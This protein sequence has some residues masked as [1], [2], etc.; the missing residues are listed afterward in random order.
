MKGELSN[1]KTCG[2][3]FLKKNRDVCNDCVQK[4]L[5][6]IES[7]KNF[8]DQSYLENV[9]LEQINLETQIEIKQIEDFLKRGKLLGYLDKI[10]INC[11]ICK[12]FIPYGQGTKKQFVCE[13]C[14]TDLKDTFEIKENKTK[15]LQCSKK[16][17]GKSNNSNCAKYGFKKSY[18]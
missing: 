9:S 3:V 18:D 15:L 8:I 13:K 16:N 14:S 4:E 12:K 6:K 1:C 7:I 17:S 2:A 11:K 5:V 10:G